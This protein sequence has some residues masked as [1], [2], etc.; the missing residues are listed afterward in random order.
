[1]S[2]CNQRA[3]KR[4]LPHHAQYTFDRKSEHNIVT[5]EVSVIVYK[6]EISLMR[7][8]SFLLIIVVDGGNLLTDPFSKGLGVP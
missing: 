3:P 2:Q 8:A 6:Y 7:D 1:M 5:E 4:D